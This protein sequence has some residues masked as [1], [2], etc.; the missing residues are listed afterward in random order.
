MRIEI[1]SDRPVSPNLAAGDNSVACAYPVSTVL[2]N[3]TVV[4]VYRRGMTK[5][6]RDGVF[7]MQA[8]PDTGDFWSAPSVIFDGAQLQPHQS[9]IMAGVCQTGAGALLFT[10]GAVEGLP[11]GVNT[12][13]E[14]SR[15]LPLRSY[16]RRSEDNGQ[17]WSSPAIVNTEGLVRASPTTKPF[18]LPDA[19][20]GLQLEYNTKIGTIGTAIAFS[21]DDGRTFEQ[22]I[23]CPADPAGQLNL[24]DAH[25]AVLPDGR[26][27]M[28]LWTF[29]QETEE[30]TEVHRSFSADGGRTWKKPEGIGFVGQVTAPLALPTG[31]VIAASNYRHP[32]EG[33]RLWHSP[34]GGENWDLEDPL[35]MWDAGTASIMA[36]PVASRPAPT[37]EEGIWESLPGFT[38]GTPDLVRLA[39][40]SIL[41]LYYATLDDVI[42]VRACRFR[43]RF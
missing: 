19:T 27:L 1:L 29:L 37:P 26:I 4:C 9:A 34:D 21:H 20:I 40:G 23:E 25:F 10:C 32:P 22:P 12:V 15:T 36:E 2:T 6:S 7:V 24:C 42:H 35:Q 38:F 30:T 8:L 31:H 13:D 43:L 33:I 3:G 41:M 11:A 28:L 39:D 17:T 16:V 14:K 18:V 5:H